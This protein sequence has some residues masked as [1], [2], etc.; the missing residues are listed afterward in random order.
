[1]GSLEWTVLIGRTGFNTRYSI[2]DPT[3]SLT[4]KN[5]TV[6]PPFRPGQGGIFW[7]PEAAR[8]IYLFL[9]IASSFGKSITVTRPLG[10]ETRTHTTRT[11]A[12]HR[13][14]SRAQSIIAVRHGAVRAARHRPRGERQGT[15][16]LTRGALFPFPS[17]KGNGSHRGHRAPTSGCRGT[18]ERGEYNM[19]GVA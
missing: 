13:V 4:I 15:S 2:P 6:D 10:T 11:R 12:R 3:L 19:D 9:G 16:W 8:D 5:P 1:M 17:R 14:V 7:P 18:V